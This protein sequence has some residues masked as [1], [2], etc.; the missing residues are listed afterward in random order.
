MLVSTA[1]VL[2]RNAY[3]IAELSGGWKGHLMR[4]ERYLI[5]LDMVP[6]MVAVGV[7]VVFSPAYFCC[8]DRHEREAKKGELSDSIPLC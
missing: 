3:R 6:M 2:V 8:D 4:T 7:F 1:M 5:A